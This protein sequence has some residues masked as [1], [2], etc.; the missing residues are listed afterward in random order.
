MNVARVVRAALLLG[1]AAC[2]IQPGTEDADSG[3]SA[4][5]R[6]RGDQCQDVLREFCQKAASCAIT[7]D[8]QTCVQGNLVLC[9][10]GS[11]CSSP[12][13][14]SEATVTACK[15]TID[16]ADCNVIAN[17]TNPTSCL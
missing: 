14:V 7:V 4:P 12:S 3:S 1:M 13:T 10:N 9:C 5:P 15:Q 2:T 8:L 16:G 6:S 17:T 11:E